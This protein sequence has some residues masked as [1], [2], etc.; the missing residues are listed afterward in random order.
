MRTYTAIALA[1]LCNTA[2]NTNSVRTRADL[3]TCD[4]S[5]RGAVYYLE[6]EDKL[7]ACK[8]GGWLEVIDSK[9]TTAMLCVKQIE[10]AFWRYEISTFPDGSVFTS[11]GVS[12][13]AAESSA[14]FVWPKASTGATAGRCVVIFDLENPSL[15]NWLFTSMSGTTKGVYSDTGSQVNGSVVSFAATDCQ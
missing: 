3:P 5:R 15:G 12:S 1:L 9:P 7:V 13:G 2:C 8:V 4:G 11:C 14:S 6:G 10:T